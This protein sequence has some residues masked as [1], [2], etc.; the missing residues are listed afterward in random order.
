MTCAGST[1]AASTCKAPDCA[2]PRCT[3]HHCDQCGD[4]DSDHRARDCPK[5]KGASWGTVGAR[6]CWKS[7]D[8]DVPAGSVGQ[9][10]CF[11]RQS[12]GSFRAQVRFPG[13]AFAFPVDSIE[14]APQ[15]RVG[16]AAQ[17]TSW[18]RRGAVA[19]IGGGKI[20]RL[21]MDPD[22]DDEVKLV[23]LDGTESPYTGVSQLRRGQYEQFYSWCRVGAWAKL[24]DDR[25]GQLTMTPD[26]DHDVV[27]RFA[28]GTDSGYVGV[29][30][31]LPSAPEGVPPLPSGAIRLGPNLAMIPSRRNDEGAD[32]ALSSRSGYE[33]LYYCSRRLGRAA[34]PGSDG[35]CGPND[36]PQ[37]ESC[38]RYQMANAPPS[39][40]RLVVGARVR[41]RDGATPAYGWGGVSPGDTGAHT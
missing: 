13:G 12:D 2:S 11:K 30:R 22:R 6:V 24:D 33:H 3:K 28:D 23:F 35:Q 17:D 25:V 40:G 19:H 1:S 4:H 8:S 41:V 37:C 16:L 29:S 20:G 31:L 5:L 38:R 10:L 34:I 9:F 21:T 7:S 15:P 26:S 18:C 36:G 14:P 27:L 32:V 39:G